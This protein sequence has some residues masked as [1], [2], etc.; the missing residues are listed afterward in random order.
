[1]TDQLWSMK[2]NFTL[3]FNVC[4]YGLNPERWDLVAASLADVINVTPNVNIQL[5]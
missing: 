4:K 5:S 2:L 1:M 3:A